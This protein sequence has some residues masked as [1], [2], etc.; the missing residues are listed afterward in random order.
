M[1][2]DETEARKEI[3]VLEHRKSVALGAIRAFDDR[4]GYLESVLER[5]GSDVV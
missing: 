1:K 3:R 4:I 2:F 5:V